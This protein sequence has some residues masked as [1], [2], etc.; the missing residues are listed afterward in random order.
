MLW[1]LTLLLAQAR[2]APDAD[3]IFVIICLAIVVLAI[4]GLWKTFEKAGQPGWAAIVPIYN[5]YVAVTIAGRP[6]WWL[7]LWFIPF[8][9]FIIGIIVFLDIAKK[10]GKGTGFGVGLFF[11]PFIFFPILGFGDARYQGPANV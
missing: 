11:L 9:N 5:I 7:L 10:F 2:N 4:A 8:V 6:W 3:P 1:S